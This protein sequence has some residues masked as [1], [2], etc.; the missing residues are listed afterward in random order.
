MKKAVEQGT[1]F[2]PRHGNLI[3]KHRVQNSHSC[4]RNIAAGFDYGVQNA[5]RVEKSSEWVTKFAVG[6][7]FCGCIW[8][9]KFAPPPPPR[10]DKGT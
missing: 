3:L 10:A 7:H 4:S 8:L 9:Q 2:T 6:A 5:K 1:G